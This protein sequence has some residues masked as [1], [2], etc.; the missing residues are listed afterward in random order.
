MLR[1]LHRCALCVLCKKRSADRVESPLLVGMPGSA[2]A[3]PKAGS[4]RHSLAPTFMES[5]LSGHPLARASPTAIR[6]FRAAGHVARLGGRSHSVV[7]HHRSARHQWRLAITCVRAMVRLRHLA[8]VSPKLLRSEMLSLEAARVKALSAEADLTSFSGICTFWHTLGISAL[9]DDAVVSLLKRAKFAEGRVLS[10]ALLRLLARRA[11]AAHL[12]HR[13]ADTDDICDALVSA[14]SASADASHDDDDA[15]EAEALQGTMSAF[16]LTARAHDFARV[17]D[18]RIAK[19]DI[20]NL[21]A[22]PATEA[23]ASPG[24]LKRIADEDEADADDTEMFF[25]APREEVLLRAETPAKEKL[26]ASASDDVD[27][28]L[29]AMQHQLSVMDIPAVARSPP[30]SNARHATSTA[31]TKYSAIAFPA[32]R[33]CYGRRRDY[34][35]V[36]VEAAIERRAKYAAGVKERFTASRVHYS[37][38]PIVV[39]SE[40]AGVRPGPAVQRPA[41]SMGIPSHSSVA[42]APQYSAPVVR[43]LRSPPRP[44]SVM[45]QEQRLARQRR[46][47]RLRATEY[48]EPLST[49][50]NDASVGSLIHRSAIATVFAPRVD[51]EPPAPSAAS[52]FAHKVLALRG[53]PP[54]AQPRVQQ[55]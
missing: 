55:V 43:P 17:D 10:E 22:P 14:A 40:L 15:V 33:D 9:D 48:R 20:R 30:P 21:L 18:G 47:R 38:K 11:K 3:S 16:G 52:I 36:D 31:S 45:T 29:A 6:R 25:A 7:R 24:D 54:P 44:A 51:I 2:Q 37:A 27:M 42:A 4:Q 1:V 19:Q 34:D 23:A 26:A 50:R 39:M 13:A 41:T 46:Q 28:S 35:V 12:V 53:G 32:L 8:R 49:V 5:S